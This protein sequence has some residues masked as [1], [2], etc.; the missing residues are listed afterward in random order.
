MLLLQHWR[1]TMR[2]QFGPAT[3]GFEAVTASDG[4]GSVRSLILGIALQTQIRCRRARITLRRPAE[5]LMR[6]RCGAEQSIVDKDLLVSITPTQKSPQ[7][8]SS[9][10]EPRS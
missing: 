8:H 9:T 4:N 6:Y 5:S 7:A 3:I 2:N 1:R 10:K